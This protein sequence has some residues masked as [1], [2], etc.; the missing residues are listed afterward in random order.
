[1]IA[2]N[3]LEACGGDLEMAVNMHMEDGPGPG[4][5]AAQGAPLAATPPLDGEEDEVRAPIPQQ[6][7]QMIQP[8]YEGYALA[9]RARGA[10]AA[11]SRK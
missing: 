3:L 4:P 2:A 11:R 8:G 5:A 6:M 7:D 9:S 1:V 10:G